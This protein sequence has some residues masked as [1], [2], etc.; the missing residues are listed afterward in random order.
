MK[1]IITLITATMSVAGL[2]IIYKLVTGLL[3]ISF[4]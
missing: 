1:L 3:S 2:V 4:V